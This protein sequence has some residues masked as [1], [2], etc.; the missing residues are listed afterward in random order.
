MTEKKEDPTITT[1]PK[2]NNYIDGVYQ[3]PTKSS[4]I[5][6]TSPCTSEVIAH[7]YKSTKEDVDVAVE[8]SKKSFESWSKLTT[9]SRVA[10]LLKFNNLVKEH[11][12]ELAELIVQEN[13]KNI[14]EGR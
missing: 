10:I 2:I 7:V 14:T 8:S 3:T 6:V 12:K 9:K 11:A 4:Y 13:G 5:P 1:T